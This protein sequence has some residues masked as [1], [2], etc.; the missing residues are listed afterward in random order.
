MKIRQSTYKFINLFIIANCLL[1]TINCNAQLSNKQGISTISIHPSGTLF[2]FGL[3]QNSTVSSGFQ[4]SVFSYVPFPFTVFPINSSVNRQGKTE[5][6]GLIGSFDLGLNISKL[7]KN[8]R[9]LR[10]EA[11]VYYA[12]IPHSYSIGNDYQ[13]SLNNKVASIWQNTVSYSGL[14]ASVTYTSKSLG[15]RGWGEARNYAQFGIR[16]MNYLDK[17]AENQ[18]D[19]VFNGKGFKTQSEV[20]NRNSFLFFLELGKT[21]WRRADDMRSL[22]MG[23]RVGI[24]TG[25]FVSNT[26]T[27]YNNNVPTAS[28]NI[29]ENGA[30]IGFQ[31]SYHLPLM[32]LQKATSKIKKADKIYCEME[33]KVV[34]KHHYRIT[35]NELQ[36]QLY[37][38]ENEDGDVVS[39]C[40]NGQ[41]LIEKHSLTQKPKIL[42]LKFLPNQQNVLTVF[43][44]NTGKEGANTSAIR[45]MLNGKMQEIILYADKK[46]SEGIEFMY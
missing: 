32:Q 8:D 7:L 21:Y 38:H 10:T 41:Y 24:P 42:I 31:M 28:N 45:F 44:H 23:I 17:S 34:V 4:Q 40:F 39:V 9:I 18:E 30:Y 43:A 19:W 16:T 22:D 1:L 20:V 35:E 12:C 37:D 27:G 13:F 29:L 14:S 33:R 2:T 46:E 25:S 36:I 6:S 26:F 15:R 11:G 5:L 3:P